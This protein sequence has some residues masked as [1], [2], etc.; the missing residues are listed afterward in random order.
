MTTLRR[1]PSPLLAATPLITMSAAPTTDCR[2]FEAVREAEGRLASL[3]D[4]ASS[5]AGSNVALPQDP[6]DHRIVGQALAGVI[7]RLK[8]HRLAGA[9]LERSCDQP[10]GQPRILGQ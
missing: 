3:T 5:N 10:I 9:A 1:S 7:E 6:L 4:S 2:R 8:R